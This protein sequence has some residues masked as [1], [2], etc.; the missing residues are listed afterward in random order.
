MLMIC[1]VM[2]LFEGGAAFEENMLTEGL[3][4]GQDLF[5][6]WACGARSAKA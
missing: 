5:G 4:F 6:V 2:F 3:A 1:E